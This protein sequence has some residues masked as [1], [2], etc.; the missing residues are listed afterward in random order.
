MRLRTS[1]SDVK[2][3]AV[4]LN[5]Y[6]VDCNFDFGVSGNVLWSEGDMSDVV[7]MKSIGRSVL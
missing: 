2:R 4:D 7:V 3:Y 5:L 1:P 6:H